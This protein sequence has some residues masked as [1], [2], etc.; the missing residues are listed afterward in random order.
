VL[1]ALPL[2]G[3][4][5]VAVELCLVLGLKPPEERVLV[6]VSSDGGALLGLNLKPGGSRAA[7]MDSNFTGEVRS[8]VVVVEV[9]ADEDEDADELLSVVVVMGLLRKLF[10]PWR[11]LKPGGN[12]LGP[13]SSN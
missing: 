2:N 6:S 3:L 1:S 5:D 8:E 7:S 12:R 13:R 10:C 9:G 11:G 4:K